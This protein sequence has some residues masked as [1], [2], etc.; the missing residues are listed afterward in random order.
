MNQTRKQKYFISVRNQLIL[1]FLVL[2]G[3]VIVFQA[4]KNTQKKMREEFLQD[5]S[6]VAASLNVDRLAH[7]AG[8]STDLQTVDYLRL[9]QQLLS[10]RKIYPSCE[11]LY[12]M[13]QKPNGQV[14][15]LADAQPPASQDYAPPGLVYDEISQ[16]YL[17][18]FKSGKPATVGP[19]TDRWG[20]LI[21]SLF[22]VKNPETDEIL[23]VLGMDFTTKEWNYKIFQ[24]LW[25]LIISVFVAVLLVFYVQQVRLLR[26]DRSARET[27]RKSQQQYKALFDNAA[28]GIIT[29]N[30]SSVITKVNHSFCEITGYTENELVGKPI[31]SLFTTA[32]LKSNPLKYEDILSGKTIQQEREMICKNGEVITVEMRSKQVDENTLQSFFRDITQRKRNERTIKEKN[33]EL[34]A[35]EEEL[36]ATNAELRNFNQKLEEQKEM[37]AQAKQKAEESD[38]LKS[39]FLAN[40]SHE[41][42][43]PMNA[44]IGFSEL[45]LESGEIEDT[46]LKPYLETIIK[47]STHLLQLIND[48]VD[49][50]KIEANQISIYPRKVNVNELIKDLEKAFHV[51]KLNSDAIEIRPEMPLS[52]DDAWLETDEVRLKQIFNNLIGNAL[53]FTR[54]GSVTFGY[55]VNDDN[56]KVF[57]VED[58]GIGIPPEK[59]QKVFDRFHRLHDGHTSHYEGTGLGLSIS[60]SLVELL[61]GQITVI[62]EIDKGARFE[63]TVNE[64]TI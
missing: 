14:V 51:Q 48:I 12:L 49:L 56:K 10:I 2:A 27:I 30:T 47:Q 28:D 61:G 41:V 17:Q 6:L 34:T 54:E 60:K 46:S 37:L 25:P 31:S 32:I 7:L 63:F 11:F 35:T 36:K 24:R 15:F 4:V 64:Y 45:I 50:S 62:S 22:P 53:K 9:K 38:Q 8:D 21:T 16:D 42:R 44:I 26:K 29:A 20:T 40:M 59:H 18:V 52:N 55:S 3:G 33:E 58:T 13:Q 43:T 5:A 57:F 1:L 23:A 39:N 19:I